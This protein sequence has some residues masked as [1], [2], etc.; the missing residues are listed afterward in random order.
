[1]K[2]IKSL[3]IL[4]CAALFLSSCAVT[5]PGAVT[6]NEVGSKTGVSTSV[7]LFAGP[8]ATVGLTKYYGLRLNP[9]FGIVEA[10]KKGKITKIGCIDYRVTN[11][12]FFTKQ[13]W[14]V[15]GE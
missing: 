8:M 4:A 11:Y 14:I 13:E 6:N 1:M 5:L 3:F 7:C 10:C 9:N 12:V 2:K 15:T